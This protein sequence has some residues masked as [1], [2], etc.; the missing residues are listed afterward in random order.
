MHQ[1]NLTGNRTLIAL[2]ESVADKL[3]ILFEGVEVKASVL[4]GD[5]WSGN[6]ASVEGHPAGAVA[7]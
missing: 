5:L 7:F 3:D 4:H 1:V 6:M 2:G